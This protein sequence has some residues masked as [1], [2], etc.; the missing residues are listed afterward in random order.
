ML[1]LQIPKKLQ[2]WTNT[3]RLSTRSRACRMSAHC[4]LVALTLPIQLSQRV[5]GTDLRVNPDILSFIFSFLSRLGKNCIDAL[6]DSKEIHS[7]TCLGHITK[8]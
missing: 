1:Q 3:I 7:T 8:C 4:Y 6:N 2:D 5:A